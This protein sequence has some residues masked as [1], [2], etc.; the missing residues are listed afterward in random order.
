[1]KIRKRL[2]EKVIE[3]FNVGV[4][5]LWEHFSDWVLMAC[6]EVIGMKRGRRSRRDTWWRDEEM[7]ETILRM[8]DDQGDV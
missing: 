2:E 8:K 7:K 5:K 3:L 6:D 1:M 4:P